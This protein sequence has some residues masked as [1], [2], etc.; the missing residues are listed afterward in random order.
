MEKKKETGQ[1]QSW[2]DEQRLVRITTC[3]METYWRFMNEGVMS[4]KLGLSTHTDTQ[5]HIH[6]CRPPFNF[7]LHNSSVLWL[8][9]NHLTYLLCARHTTSSVDIVVR[10]TD[11]LPSPQILVSLKL[12]LLTQ[13]CG[14]DSSHVVKMV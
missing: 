10:K 11:T 7:S 1:G 8:W 13:N 3:A 6:P 14:D 12:K 4:F 5:S 2:R 9:G